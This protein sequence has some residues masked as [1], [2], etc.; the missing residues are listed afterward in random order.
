MKKTMVLAFVL[1]VLGISFFACDSGSTYVPP[2]GLT[3]VGPG[4]WTYTLDDGVV[5][6]RNVVQGGEYE[7]T[8]RTPLPGGPNFAT[9]TIHVSVTAIETQGN[10]TRLTLAPV[11]AA[12]I[13]KY[14]SSFEVT[15][16]QKGDMLQIKGLKGSQT[17]ALI[18]VGNNR[19]SLDGA[20]FLWFK[21]GGVQ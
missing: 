16:D 21:N 9:E 5:R 14:G 17:G 8:V 6:S 18:P 4:A 11:T 19:N 7:L 2:S 15:L 1:A 13:D 3:A 12:A 10:N 20:W